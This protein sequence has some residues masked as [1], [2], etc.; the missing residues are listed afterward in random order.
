LALAAPGLALL[1]WPVRAGEASPAPVVAGFAR[2]VRLPHPRIT[3]SA[4]AYPG[5]GCNA[6]NILDGIA[7]SEYASHAKGTNTFIDFDFGQPTLVAGLRHIDRND[8]ATV[9]ASELVFMD[10]TDRVLAAVPVT[11]VNQR[12][13]V[14]FIALPSP[15]TASRVRWRVTRLGP[16]RHDC[17]GGAELAFYTAA[18]AEPLPRGITIEAV[19]CPVL[20][21]RG[22]ALV[23][24]LQV[25]FD[26][27]YGRPVEAVVRV[28][29]LDP[30]DLRLALGTPSFAAV[31]PAVQAEERRAITVEV[32]GQ[33]VARGQVRVRPVRPMTIYLLPHS[34]VDIGYTELQAEVEKKQMRNI[35]RGIELARA[36]A[37]YPAGARFKWNVEVLWAVDSYLR[38]SP[39]EKQQEF[40]D[41][42]RQGWVGLDAMYG[43]ELTGLCRPEELLRLFRYATE[44]GRRCGV[45]VES[46]MISDVPG[47]VWGTVPAMAHAGVK[48]FSI[49][50]N[51]F[52]RIGTTLEDWE[53]KVF[54]WVSASGEEEVLCWVPYYGYALSHVIRELTEPFMLRQALR[55][56]E[57]DYPYQVAQL[58]WSGLGDNAAPDEQVPAF[59]RQWNEKY[60]QP[61]LAIATTAEAFRAFERQHGR[62]VPRVRGEYT[63]YWEDGAATS[64]RETALN[65]ASAERLVQA[66]TLWALRGRSGFPAREFQAAWRNVLLYSEHTWGAHNSVS[67]PDLP[68]VHEQ[69]RVKQGFAIEADRQSRALLAQALAASGTNIPGPPGAA[70]RAVDV[71]NTCSWPRTD[72]VTLAPEL[73]AGGDR[74]VDERGKPMASQRLASGELAFLATDVPPLA[75]KRFRL[76]AGVPWARG[77]VKAEGRT[78]LHPDFRLRLD[79]RT[80]AIASWWSRSLGRELVDARAAT[81]LNDYFYLLGANAKDAIRNGPPRI[82]VRENGPLVAA[83]LVESDA[84]GCRR[85]AREVRA[86]A[87]LDRVEVMNLVDKLPVRAK[88]GVHF[89]FGFDVPDGTIRMDTGWTAVRPE[90]DQLPASC[91][92]S[93]SVQRWVDVANDR[94]GVTWTSVDAPLI[95]I[96]GLTGII[97]AIPGSQT[98]PRS[99]LRHIEPSQTI[100]SWVMNNHWHT[101]YRAEQDGPTLFRYRLRPHRGYDPIE[102]ARFGVAS[103]QPLLVARAAGEAVSKPRFKLTS[104]RV[105]VT[106]F[107]PSDDGQAWIVRL[108]G[109]AGRAEKVKLSW[110]EPRPRR[111]WRSDT[112]EQPLEPVPETVRVPGWGI[113]TLRLEP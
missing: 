24:P 1:G 53:N 109:A 59:V 96:G 41:A 67:Q 92:N 23:Q 39:P 103:S 58:R 34:H 77:G 78:L 112:S 72:L 28:E 86:V 75:I 54:Y 74:V 97:G 89:G 66:E 14:T 55:Y 7:R 48:Y 85:L 21:R 38:Q 4:A 8:P 25:T 17:V 26:Y 46:A 87:G 105:L 13:G 83:L 107:K 101:N 31:L 47:Y 62:E 51:Y 76:E 6:T 19:A 64:A 60:A 57:A 27:S 15:V 44:L 69:W 84:P 5:G 94:F 22:A 91:K 35:A 56:Q 45:P 110:T 88:E 20:E 63:P 80:G 30:R 33:T 65:R 52:D 70:G 108:F 100:Y 93:I 79:E 11:H 49:A 3:G 12:S 73:A 37:D 40:I 9:V 81:A 71:F 61:R 102:A 113:V 43:N 16:E 98:D 10:A 18:G 99:F 95:E 42:V 90:L 104:D 111:V 50:P 82:S 2:L 68:F 106:A 29:G 32:A 36:T